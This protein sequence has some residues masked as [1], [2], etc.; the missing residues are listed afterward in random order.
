MINHSKNILLDNTQWEFL[1]GL[2]EHSG[3]TYVKDLTGNSSI[4]F[5]YHGF[6]VDSIIKPYIW[7]YVYKHG[8]SYQYKI[9]Q[10]HAQRHINGSQIPLLLKY[11]LRSL[12]NKKH[13]N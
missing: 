9:K 3:P 11:T 13:L 4:K 2:V 8:Q 7:M 6:G 5:N 12:W 1:Y 10:N